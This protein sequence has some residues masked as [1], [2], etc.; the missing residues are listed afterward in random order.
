MQ[1][2]DLFV[3]ALTAASLVGAVVCFLVLF[4]K[5]VNY[6]RRADKPL[7]YH[8]LKSIRQNAAKSYE[9]TPAEQ[10]MLMA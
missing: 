8:S 5:K 10:E 3:L 6:L 7:K 9:L 1:S 2:S 4:T